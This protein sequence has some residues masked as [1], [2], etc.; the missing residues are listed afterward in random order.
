MNSLPESALRDR[1]NKVWSQDAEARAEAQ[2]WY[3]MAHP[4]VRARV[5]ILISGDPNC[6]AYGRLERLFRERA[7]RVPIRRAVSLGCGFGNLERDLLKRGWVEHFSAYDLAEG[8][9]Q[10]AEYLARADGLEARI[11]YAVAD[12]NLI[13]LPTRSVDAVF[14]HSAV[15][16]V[17]ALERLYA[18]VHGALR[19]GG[20]FHLHEFVGPTRFQ[21]TDTQLRL[22]NA[23]MD[24]LPPRLRRLTSL[25]PKGAL[26]RPTI[27][28]MIGS[29]PSESVR[30]ADLVRALAPWFEIVEERQIG[31]ALLHLALGDIAQNFDAGR[32]ED[33]TFLL[34]LFE[35]EDKAMAN[36]TIGSDFVVLT[37]VAKSRAKRIFMP[38]LQSFLTRLALG[39]PSVPRLHDALRRLD[40]ATTTQIASVS[41]P[42]TPAAP[43]SAPLF[44]PPGHYYSPIVNVEELK[45]RLGVIFDR[46]RRPAN[47][48]LRE[49]AQLAWLQRVA[50][51]YRELTFAMEAKSSL[52]YYYDNQFFS[53]GDGIVLGCTILAMRPKRIVEIGSGFSSALMLDV[54]DST[55]DLATECMF[56]EPHTERLDGLL[57]PN[58]NSRV[59]ILRH[60]V[61]DVDIAVFERLEQ[62]DILFIDS[63]HIVKTGS[64]VVHYMTKILPVLAPGVLIH[65]HDIFYPFE[66][67]E[68]WVLDENRSW[69]EIYMVWAFLTQNRAY[70]IEFFNDF[71]GRT[72][73][74]LM[75]KYLPLFMNNP[76]G[77]LWL[78]KLYC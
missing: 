45:P 17:E 72:Y 59:E 43:N 26:R 31:G 66:Y 38:R 33:R 53:F 46:T 15:H 52:R 7:W 51:F 4:M 69:N 30:S 36:G 28:E 27:D 12:L 74:S 73:P 34:E 67:P 16:H 57:W 18:T 40:A 13:E 61:Q 19:P 78:R 6:D 37:A 54:L 24:T 63:S 1:V 49:K 23:W 56:I 21:W 48:D 50:P 55:P 60:R 41:P 22:V 2:G 5:N 71:M 42:G 62:N 3:W 32:T 58:D 39:V 11:T 9:V 65:I 8:A 75:E 47:I 76:G 44:I 35:T 25:G 68:S 10:Q 77:S 14:A 29:D 20:V 70:Q 64:D